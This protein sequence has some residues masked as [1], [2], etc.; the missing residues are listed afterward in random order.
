MSKSE[1]FGY[2]RDEHGNK[3]VIP[4]QLEALKQAE[5]YIMQGCTMQSARDWLVNKTG[6]SIS[7]PGLLKTLRYN[8]REKYTEEETS[9]DS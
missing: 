6:R 5:Y 8:G 7:V 3:L 1:P 4:E 2:Y 9:R